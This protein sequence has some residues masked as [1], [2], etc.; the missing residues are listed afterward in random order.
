MWTYRASTD[1]TYSTQP[2]IRPGAF[3]TT[4]PVHAR[5]YEP[6][7]SSY[8]ENFNGYTRS[9][10]SD[11]GMLLSRFEE[12]ISKTIWQAVCCTADNWKKLLIFKITVSVDLCKHFCP[13]S[14]DLIRGLMLSLWCLDLE[15]PV[16]SPAV[17]T[18]MIL[19]LTRKS[20]ISLFMLC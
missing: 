15:T 6:I 8:V 20:L 12:P 9:R 19:N 7:W 14:T 3:K 10:A 17:L 18:H 13:R 11:L 1:Q 16:S 4:K 2:M 5:I